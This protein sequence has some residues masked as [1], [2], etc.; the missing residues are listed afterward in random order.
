MRKRVVITGF[1]L[2]CGMGRNLDE[3]GA[4]LFAG[5]SCVRRLEPELAEIDR[6]F[7]WGGQL[8]DFQIADELPGIDA[9]RVLRFSQFA[10]VAA[11]RAIRHAQL[12]LARMDR[13]RIGTVFGTAAAGLG[14]TVHVEVKRFF[15]RSGNAHAV[16]PLAW[17]E[18]TPCACTTHV[19]IQYGLCGPISTLSSGCVT[20]IDGVAWAVD[21]IREGRADVMLAGGADAPFFPFMWAGFTRSGIMAPDPLD[22]GPVPRPF[23]HDHTGITLVEGGSAVILESETHARLRGATIY[24]DIEGIASLDDGRPL[25]NLDPSGEAYARTIQRTLRDAGQPPTALDWLCAHGTGHPGADCAESRGI[26]TALGD[27]AFHL[28]VSSVRGAIGQSFAS[29]GGFQ[30]AAACVALREGR[31]PATLNFS[32]PAEDCRLDYVPNVARP[33]RLR[34]VMVCAAGI[35]GTHSGVLVSTYER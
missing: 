29:G 24:G 27:F 23:A 12:D 17:A 26:E 14:D 11:D 25:S 21:Q 30:L 6:R 20:G 10:L 7:T 5:T 9:K 22:G 33:A 15:A 4:A 34:R 19:A 18:F 3:F 13:T 2:L 28:P 31:V 32:R 35:G 16:S 1:G 8:P